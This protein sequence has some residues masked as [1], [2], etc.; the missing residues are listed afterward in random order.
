MRYRRRSGLEQHVDDVE[1]NLLPRHFGLPGVLASGA[2][3]AGLLFGSDGA[4]R[5]AVLVGLPGFD[6]HEDQRIAFPSNEI[7]LTGSGRQAVIAIH[8]D[9][10]GALQKPLGDILATRPSA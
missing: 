4:I 2:N 3:Q 10:S 7:H 5:R 8:D 1:S 9:D 6:F